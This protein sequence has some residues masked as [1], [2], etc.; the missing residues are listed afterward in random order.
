MIYKKH[1]IQSTEHLPK[2]LGLYRARSQR[3]K[4][5][6]LGRPTFC[7]ILLPSEYLPVVDMESRER[8]A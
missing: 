8:T 1:L 5:A 7:M 2:Q 6:L 3:K 4:E